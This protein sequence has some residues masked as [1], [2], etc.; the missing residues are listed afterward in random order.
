MKQNMGTTDRIVR[1][2]VV[3]PVLLVIGYLVG[4]ATVVG[5]IATVLAVVMLGTAA[6]G[7][8]PLYMPLH[9]HTDHRQG[10]GT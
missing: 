5:V 2:I 3:A 7:F 8:C 6:V 9:L 4:F 1:A 10:A